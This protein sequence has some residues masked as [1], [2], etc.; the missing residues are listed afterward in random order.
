MQF[1]YNSK[2]YTLQSLKK[3]ARYIKSK[4]A[5]HAVGPGL[6]DPS[7]VYVF[8]TETAFYKWTETLR[9][10]D[11]FARIHKTVEQLRKFEQ[12]DHAVLFQRQQVRLSRIREDLEELASRTGL[13]LNSKELFLQA[14]LEGNPLEGSVFDPA[15]LYTGANFT[16]NALGVGLPLPNLNVFPVM[17]NTVSSA[18]VLGICILCNA[19]WFGGARLAL[20]GAPYFESSNLATLGFNDIASSVFV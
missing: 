8:D 4:T 9:L 13:P 19:A 11:E 16:G 20:V 6:P 10:A 1:L 12:E 15:M 18:R 2:T 17:N 3:N 14:T 7:I 5:I